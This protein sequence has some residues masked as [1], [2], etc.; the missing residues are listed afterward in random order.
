MLHMNLFNNLISTEHYTPNTHY[1]LHH[2]CN[3]ALP[4]EVHIL[5]TSVL[6]QD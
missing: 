5:N 3:N 4:I 2:N 6:I 1:T